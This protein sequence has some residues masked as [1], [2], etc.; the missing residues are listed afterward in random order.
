LWRAA[1]GTPVHTFRGHEGS[2]NGVGFSPDGRLLASA[3]ADH[4]VRLWDLHRRRE[5]DRLP[6]HTEEVRAVAFRP[7]GRQLASA[8]LDACLRLWDTATRRETS[9]LVGHWSLTL[10]GVAYAPDG[11][12][13]LDC[14]D[15]G[16]IRVWHADEPTPN[17]RNIVGQDGDVTCAA[18][19]RDGSLLAT[20]GAEGLTIIWDDTGTV[21]NQLPAPLVPRPAPAKDRPD[22]GTGPLSSGGRSPSPASGGWVTAVAFSPDGRLLASATS[23][24]QPFDL[25]GPP[26]KGAGIPDARLR[27]WD[28]ASGRALR[29]FPPWTHHIQAVA[30]SRDGRLLAAAGAWTEADPPAGHEQA[31]RER[32]WPI[33]LWDV[34]TGQEVQTLRGHQAQVNALAF[35]RDGRRLISGSDDRTVRAWD[36]SNGQQRVVLPN[37][38]GRIYTLALDPADRHL[39]T[40]TRTA[41]EV[42]VWDMETGARTQRTTQH[43]QSITGLAYS[44]D[45]RRLFTV[46]QDRSLKVWDTV[47][48]QELLTLWGHDHA[49]LGLACSTD[50]R[51][52]ASVGQAGE[53]RVWDAPT[54]HRVWWSGLERIRQPEQLLAWHRR[55]AAAAE[56]AE[57]WYGAAWH[58]DRLLAQEPASAALRARRDRVRTAA[59]A[60]VAPSLGER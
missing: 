35:T 30:F 25:A 5:L 27:L 17:W 40:V 48:G 39:A 42:H 51:Q 46:S 52:L 24:A 9:C 2:V 20:G 37:A 49:A 26:R 55:E 45:G 4:T 53:V 50:G 21:R 36:L 8:G 56:A 10:N 29:A 43:R 33:K 32:D 31:A 59:G 13:V 11:A 38:P 54:L 7:D 19:N 16:T 41:W 18:F 15:D 58:L 44:P 3:G 47:N 22:N 34:G 12:H 60:M 14:S 57:D 28:V 1:D 6:G 23:A